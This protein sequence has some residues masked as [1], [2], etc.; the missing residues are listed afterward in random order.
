MWCKVISRNKQTATVNFGKP[1]G[2][3]LLRGLV[4]DADVLV[5]NFGPGVMEK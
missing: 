1:E 2:Q 5:E 4:A 3:E